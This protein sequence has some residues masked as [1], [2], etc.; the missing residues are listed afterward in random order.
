MRERDLERNARKAC[1][2][3]D[4]HDPVYLAHIHCFYTGKTVQEVLYQHF[5]K[6][7]D[8][9]QV[10]DFI[11]FY[12]IFVKICKL[13]FLDFIESDAKFLAAFFQYC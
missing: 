1:A 6:F 12:K 3:S 8:T 7:C 5:L 13:L 4:I 2:C 11:F 9:G 10:H